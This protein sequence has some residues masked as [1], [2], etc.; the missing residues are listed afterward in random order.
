MINTIFCFREQEMIRTTTVK[1]SPICFL[2]LYSS[3]VRWR[4][5]RGSP[6]RL[7]VD[8]VVLKGFVTP[9]RASRSL[10]R[11]SAA[12]KLKLTVVVWHREGDE[13]PLCGHRAATGALFSMT[14]WQ[15]C[16]PFHCIMLARLDPGKF[17]HGCQL[18]KA[19][20]SFD[21]AAG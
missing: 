19:S 5:A 2:A 17:S 20:P 18:A 6:W 15:S 10:K 3:A 8:V 16:S 13:F 14:G 7:P 12:R 4:E 9:S 21:L 11:K 1:G